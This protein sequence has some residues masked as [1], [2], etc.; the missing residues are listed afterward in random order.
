MPSRISVIF[1]LFE[2]R[3]PVRDPLLAWAAQLPD[4]DRLELVVVVVGDDSRSRELRDILRPGDRVVMGRFANLAAMYDSGV[5]AANGELVF[6]TEAHCRPAP[7]CLEATERYLAEHPEF[8]GAA[9]H[10]V[11]SCEN[12]Y[13]EIDAETFHEGFREFVL[14]GDWRKLN[15]H[16]FALRR[17]VYLKLGG[18]EHQYGRFAEMLLAARLRDAGYELGYVKDA[19]VIHHYRGTLGELIRG[20][21]DYIRGESVYRAA[22]PGRDRVGYTYLPEVSDPRSAI[23]VRLER[24]VA[25]AL[26]RGVFGTTPEAAGLGLRVAAGAATRLLGR[27]GPVLAAWLGVLA[28]RV[29]CWWHQ[30]DRIRLAG[31]Y[32]DLIRRASALSRLRAL[33]SLPRDERGVVPLAGGWDVE[34]LPD[35]SLYGFHGTEWWRGRAFRWSSPLA[36]L[37]LPLGPMVTALRVVTLGLRSRR[38][39]VNLR[40]SVDGVRVEVREPAEGVYELLIPAAERRRSATV[41]WMCDPLCPWDEGVRDHR[42]LGLP[43]FRLV[44]CASGVVSLRRVA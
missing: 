14:P 13:A 16:G 7:G 12:A 2:E 40:A 17:S 43:V 1:P 11:P 28:A 22:H 5:R 41:I 9:T 6:L 19:A 39:P 20:I 37:R 25:V 26:L 24:A 31:A 32:R 4:A 38:Y 42:E 34:E 29:R 3:G 36:A 35:C 27:R 30:R 33:A 10:S 21:D 18:L 23:A 15:V 44:A 8:A